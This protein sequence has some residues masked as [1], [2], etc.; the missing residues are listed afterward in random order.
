MTDPRA[1]I[2]VPRRS[3][4][5]RRDELWRFCRNFWR[6]HLPEYPIVEADDPGDAPFNR[7]AAIN[8]GAA[9]G[10]E[11]HDVLIILDGDVLLDPTVVR[12]AVHACARDGSL[13]LPFTSRDSLGRVGSDRVTVN[14]MNPARAAN[15]IERQP[16]NV[17]TCVVVP[18]TL[19]ADVRGFDERFIGWGGE[20]DAF[21][22]ACRAL[23][24]SVRHRGIA[25]HLWHE[26]SPWHGDT[27]LRRAATALSDRYVATAGIDRTRPTGGPRGG[28][29][30]WSL[31]HESRADDQVV[32][33]ALTNGR[34]PKLLRQALESFEARVTGP[35]GRRLLVG[36]QC[37][38]TFDGWQ[39]VQIRGGS[40]RA[41]MQE[42]TYRALG[43]GQPWIFWLEDDFIF[44]RGVSLEDMQ[45]VLTRHPHLVQVS[46]MR[47]A[48]YKPE[49]AAGSVYATAPD[50]FVQRDGFVEHRKYWTQNPM[51]TRR[52]V[53]AEHPWP[54][55]S[56]SEQA[57]GRKVLADQERAC[58]VMG[59]LDDPPWVT[60]IGERRAGQTRGY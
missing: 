22:A 59:S 55:V 33:V 30:M 19:F 44:E 29:V 28:G 56:S 45:D 47:Q 54:Q 32:V 57:F 8:R 20:D 41:A 49:I 60:H 25:W 37:A 42:A 51:L 17:S 40:Y 43:S 24:G 13:H 50:A 3:D 52:S 1:R 6:E 5:G 53:F 39:T 48:W 46:L 2:V 16:W 4:G 15:V 10:G 9:L 7:A 11:S 26:P 58:A 21:H 12:Q 34:R 35:V 18:R 23:A 36:D 38:P 31:L 14:G 27:G